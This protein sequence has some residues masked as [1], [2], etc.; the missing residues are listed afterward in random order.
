MKMARRHPDAVAGKTAAPFFNKEQ[1]NGFFHAERMVAKSPDPDK[2]KPA[3]EKK[4]EVKLLDAIKLLGAA[5]PHLGDPGQK[6]LLESMSDVFSD[7]KRENL[8]LL[9]TD[10]Q[11]IR[12]GRPMRLS[13]T[14]QQTG[15]MSKPFEYRLYIDLSHETEGGADAYFRHTDEYG[16]FMVFRIEKLKGVSEK[17]VAITIA[18]ESVHLFAH[19]QRAIRARVGDDAAMRVPGKQA[20]TIMDVS[21]FSDLKTAFAGHFEK[22][23]GFLNQQEHRRFSLDKLPAGIVDDWTRKVVE[24]TMAFVYGSRI[25]QALEAGKGKPTVTIAFEPLTFLRR[26]MTEQ[27]LNEKADQEAMDTKEGKALLEEMKADM[28]ALA[29][30][31]EKQV[32][33]FGKSSK[34]P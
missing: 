13:Y 2:E 3:E 20:A 6:E 7:V 5:G 16:G 33:A 14:F 21:G 24:E 15:S 28:L 32:G 18:H 22:V 1:G 30:A 11:R 26:Y 27:W 17:E 12:L 31:M 19:L 8:G 9:G 23:R 25:D 29:D 34:Q 10:G 4:L